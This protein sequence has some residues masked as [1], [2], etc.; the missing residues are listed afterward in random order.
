MSIME[1]IGILAAPKRTSQSYPVVDLMQSA[2]TYANAMSEVVSSTNAKPV[3][4]CENCEKSPEKILG[5]TRFA[6]C[7]KCKTNLN[8]IVHYC[9]S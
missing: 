6:I 3:I 8:L 9:S 2:G 4:R 5:N 7:S 1:V